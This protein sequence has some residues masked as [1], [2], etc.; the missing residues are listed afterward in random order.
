MA[1]PRKSK[2]ETKQRRGS[3]D[4]PGPERAEA[5]AVTD[6][7][8]RAE[9]WEGV[10]VADGHSCCPG[11]TEVKDMGCEGLRQWLVGGHTSQCEMHLSD[12]FRFASL[13]S[14]LYADRCASVHSVMMMRS[15]AR[16]LAVGAHQ[17]RV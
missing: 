17:F 9:G 11:G 6:G 12:T 1:F 13:T 16:Y 2:K 15:L 3:L 7:D 5:G 8:A 10:A 4:T 14:I